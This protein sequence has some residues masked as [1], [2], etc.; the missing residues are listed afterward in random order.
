MSPAKF[1]AEGEAPLV[2]SVRLRE[3]D[4]VW[5]ELV[6]R[7][8]PLRNAASL[9]CL[10]ILANFTINPDATLF[11][12]RDRNFYSA[13]STRRYYPP[14]Y[15]YRAMISAV[16]VLVRAGLVDGVR[17]SPSPR[18]TTRSTLRATPLLKTLLGPVPRQAVEYVE[19]EVIVLRQRDRSKKLIDYDDTDQ[20]R[21]M[22]AEVQAQ[23]A[24]LRQF[25]VRL[26]GV[27]NVVMFEGRRYD[28]FFK[29][30]YR[31]FNGDFEHGG[32][33][34]GPAWQNLPKELRPRLTI[35]GCETCE[36][37]FRSCHPRLLCASAGLQLPFDDPDFDFYGLA[38]FD[39]AEVKV[40]V[41]VLLNAPTPRSAQGALIQ[42]LHEAGCSDAAARAK[43]LSKAVRAAWPQLAPY[44]G[45]GVGLRLQRIDADICTRGAEEPED[46]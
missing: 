25:V 7:L 16:D 37:D 10:T 44:W 22:R 27:H 5:R 28:L 30:A 46:G 38:S 35:D 6:A 34:Y 45:T 23:N 8:G 20:T 42:G 21:A 14:Y 36:C 17:T 2:L 29:P 3:D 33:W 32:R 39:R 43:S 9:M 1:R 13:S 24:F 15:T 19:N 41:Q 40:A 31:V 18:A 26:D 12:S 11:Y 4:P